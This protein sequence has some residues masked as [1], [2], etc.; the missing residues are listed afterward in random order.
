MFNPENNLEKQPWKD[1][2]EKNKKI[3]KITLFFF[4]LQIS[5]I[6]HFLGNDKDVLR[7]LHSMYSKWSPAYVSVGVYVCEEL[8]NDR[9][10]VILKPD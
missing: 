6:N 7:K 8:K 5:P 1:V 10:K 3:V 2:L 9:L 4:C